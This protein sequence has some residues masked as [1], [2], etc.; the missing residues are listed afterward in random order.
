[1]RRPRLASATSRGTHALVPW[2][3][4]ARTQP[5]RG[6]LKL[7]HSSSASATQARPHQLKLG[8]QQLP[9]GL[10]HLVR[11]LETPAGAEHWHYSPSP[12]NSSSA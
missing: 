3:T 4:Q 10:G 9:L 12:R 1:M 2:S 6:A 11:K 7:G 5:S 8:L